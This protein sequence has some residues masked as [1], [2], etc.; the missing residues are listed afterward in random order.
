MTP[1]TD[2]DWNEIRSTIPMTRQHIELLA[3]LL[4]D[5]DACLRQPCVLHTLQKA[6]HSGGIDA[7]SLIDGVGFQ[8]LRLRASLAPSEPSDD[9]PATE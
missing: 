3:Q 5:L 8:A 2:N 7:G 1:H 4:T 6:Q 9:D